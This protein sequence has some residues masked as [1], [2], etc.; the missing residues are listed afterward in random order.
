MLPI[1]IGEIKTYA[2]YDTGSPI[3]LIS[4]KKLKQFVKNPQIEASDC[5]VRSVLG[6]PLNV[7]G[8]TP[9]QITMGGKTETVSFTAVKDDNIC[10]FAL[11]GLTI[12][13]AQINVEKEVIT[14]GLT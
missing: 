2:V 1:Q 7:I 5:N 13:R 14:V 8:V 3:C 12:F 4:L 11:D 9:L 10:I 6:A